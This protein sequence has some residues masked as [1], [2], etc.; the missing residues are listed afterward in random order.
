MWF[1]ERRLTQDSTRLLLLYPNRVSFSLL[2]FMSH[3]D[4]RPQISVLTPVW[5]R[6][7]YLYRVYDSLRAQDFKDFEWI[8]ANDGSTDNSLSIAL[9]LQRESPFRMVIISS[10]LRIGKPRMDNE[11]L[12]AASGRLILWCDS[13][14]YITPQCL[15]RLVEEWEA[16]AKDEVDCYIGVTALCATKEGVLQS[17]VPKKSG[18]LTTTWAELDTVHGVNTDTLIM[19]D[20]TKVRHHRFLE[21]D[22]MITEGSLWYEFFDYKT[23]FIPEVLKVMDRTV[24][25]RISMTRKMEYCRGKAYAMTLCHML[26]PPKSDLSISYAKL[27]VTY[28]R[29]CYHGDIGISESWTMW[30][31]RVHPITW[32]TLGILSTLL[33]LY[34]QIML[35]VVKTH[36]QHKANSAKVTISQIHQSV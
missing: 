19:F 8:V 33:A 15:N 5:N 10:S 16:I 4:Q 3:I 2:A 12:R 7:G 14:D 27:I 23:V 24:N 1:S 28:Q 21:V 30:P 32:L 18:V 29:Y 36:R 25:N 26:R 31:K 17:T 9:E 20:A 11:L 34:D 35:R 6:A 22:L 13:D